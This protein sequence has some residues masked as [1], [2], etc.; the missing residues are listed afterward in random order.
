VAAFEL[1]NQAWPEFTTQ[2]K[3]LLHGLREQVIVSRDENSRRKDLAL[4]LKERVRI[5]LRAA[6]NSSPA[7]PPNR[8]VESGSERSVA[9][10]SQ[11][12]F[13]TEDHQLPYPVALAEPRIQ[14]CRWHL[15]PTLSASIN[16]AVAKRIDPLEI[17]THSRRSSVADQE[18]SLQRQGEARASVDGV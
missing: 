5:V 18:Y 3:Q 6:S 7:G 12:A 4:P 14:F 17:P 8:S 2:E 9:E 10:L 11:R 15:L 16:L 13:R 1:P